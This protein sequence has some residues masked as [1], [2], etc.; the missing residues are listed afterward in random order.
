M[1]A[2]LR[3]QAD[4]AEIAL[5]AKAAWIAHCA[6][7]EPLEGSLARGSVGAIIA[8]TEGEARRLGAEEVYIAAAPDLARDARFRRVEGEA[9]VGAS[10]AL[11]ATVAYKGTWLRLVRTFGQGAL[12]EEATRCFAAAV[13]RLPSDHGLAGFA[14]WLVEGCRIAQ[15]L[16]PLLGSRVNVQNPIPARAL[17]SV[18]GRL[19]LGGR[20]VLLGAP[21]LLGSPGE[22]AS[23]LVHPVF[24][25]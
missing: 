21:A 22:A 5:A 16:E 2:R 23:L 12:V 15:P 13:A 18:Q 6:L 1:F 7:A 11:R 19:E 4:P 20:P 8:A 24:D 3:A 10:F 9:S 14:S 25:M 17:V